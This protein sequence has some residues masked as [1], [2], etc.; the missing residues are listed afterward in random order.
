MDKIIGNKRVYPL[1]AVDQRS[2]LSPSL[3]GLACPCP[4]FGREA[5]SAWCRN[6]PCPEPGE[7]AHSADSMRA[8]GNI[9]IHRDTCP[10]V[11]SFPPQWSPCT[12][13]S[14]SS[15]GCCLLTYR[16]GFRDFVWLKAKLKILCLYPKNLF[17]E[18]FINACWK[19]KKI[20]L[21]VNSRLHSH[22]NAVPS[23]IRTFEEYSYISH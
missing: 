14:I 22:R 20:F 9:P 16:A 19:H 6:A 13:P 12:G 21:S 18:D 10:Q 4:W 23:I 5:P 2:T 3:Q 15:D 7:T 1:P 17:A 8:S 11:N